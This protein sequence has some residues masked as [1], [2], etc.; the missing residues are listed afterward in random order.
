MRNHF[1]VTYQDRWIDRA[2]PVPWSPDLTLL[3][4]FLWGNM[5][6]MVYG[7]AAT[8][9]KDLIARVCLYGAIESLAKQPHLLG[10]MLYSIV[11]LRF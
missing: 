6:G 1:N 7:T 5:K 10:Y 11:Y 2:G 9:E 8:S 4:Y 3:D